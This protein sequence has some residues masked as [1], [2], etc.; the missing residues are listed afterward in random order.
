MMSRDK[1]L[2]IAG[3]TPEIEQALGE[4]RSSVKAWSEATLRQPMAA[5][6]PAPR[7][8][9]W[10]GRLA[11]ALGFVLAIGATSGAIYE[12][13]HQ[14]VLAWQAQQRVVKLQEQRAQAARQA[15]EMDQLMAN[16]DS[17]VSQEVPDA[18]EPLAQMM[19]ETGSN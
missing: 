13:H 3:S 19:T 4:F 11:W 8:L 2:E 6:A 14:R 16:V 15:A 1:G 7:G 9:A 18:L 10:R 12:N 17:D 5:A